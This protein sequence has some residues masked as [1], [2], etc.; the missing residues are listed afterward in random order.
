MDLV[1]ARRREELP[2]DHRRPERKDRIHG[3]D[4]QGRGEGAQLR[5]LEVHDVAAHH[6]HERRP[7]IRLLLPTLRE[8]RGLARAL[9]RRAARQPRRRDLHGVLQEPRAGAAAPRRQG[10]RRPRLGRLHRGARARL[11]HRAELAPLRGQGHPHR[12]REAAQA[13][14]HLRGQGADAGPGGDGG[15]LRAQPGHDD[16]RHDPRAAPVGPAAR[17]PQGGAQREEPGAHGRRRGEQG[18]RPPRHRHAPRPPRRE[19]RLGDTAQHRARAQRHRVQRVER[20][21]PRAA[22]ARHRGAR[23]DVLPPGH[24]GADARRHGDRELVLPEPRQPGAHRQVW[25]RPSRAL[26]LREQGR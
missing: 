15:E 21:Q 14:A 8:P 25:R 18:R 6:E 1:A 9:Q 2:Q 26:P 7:P 20:E 13:G 4:V 17:A 11:G 22:A 24:R 5:D 10:A 3:A 23:G 19:G 16:A 12:A